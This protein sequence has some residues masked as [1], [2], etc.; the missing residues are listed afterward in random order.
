MKKKTIVIRVLIYLRKNAA[1]VILHN[2]SYDY[3]F[4][5]ISK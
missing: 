3:K 4:A 1:G 2:Y 5:K